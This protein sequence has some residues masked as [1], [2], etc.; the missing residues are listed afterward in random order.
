MK[1]KSIRTMISVVLLVSI[2]IGIIPGNVYASNG[3]EES[4]TYIP[5]MV[6]E[7]E[8]SFD[9]N[10]VEK[11]PDDPGEMIEASGDADIVAE[12][13]K[14]DEGAV[15]GKEEN[16]E[17]EE[18]VEAE[19]SERDSSGVL[20]ADEEAS[21][22]TA[23]GPEY[24]LENGVLTIT[25][26]GAI[27]EKLYQNNTEI[28]QIVMGEGISEI[29]DYAFYGCN[30]LESV[31]FSTSLTTIGNYAFSKCTGLE[32]VELPEGVST[33]GAR[34]FEN[35]TLLT[36]VTIPVSV[37]SG[38]VTYTYYS[39]SHKALG[40][41]NGCSNLTTVNFAEGTTHIHAGLFAGSGLKE[42][43]IPETVA[44][45]GDYAFASCTFLQ[46]INFPVSLE[47]ISGYVFAN[48]TALQNIE[49]PEGISEIGDYAFYKCTSLE[50]IEL[51][52]GLS[53]LGLRVF[54]NCKSLIEVTLSLSI[55]NGASSYTY[56]TSSHEAWGTF[57]GCS[58]L[59][60]VN[61][62]D[63]TTRIPGGLFAGSGIK[64]IT[65]PETVTEIGSYAF[66]SC[67]S[68]QGINFP[69]S[70]EKIRGHAFANCTALQNIEYPDGI[71]E[72]GDYT[73]YGC[74]S[75]ERIEFPEGLSTLGLRVF[76]NCKGLIE[77]TLSLSVLNGASSYTYNSSSHEA[78]GTFNGCSSLTTVNFPD[79]T[80]WIPGGF[81]AGSGIKEIVIPETVTAIGSYAFANSFLETI[82]I[83]DSVTAIGYCTFAVCSA[84]NY[85][86]MPKNW[87]KCTGF[88]SS[89]GV[90]A[91]GAI[92]YDCPL[93]ETVELPEGMTELPEYAFSNCKDIKYIVI[94]ESVQT[95]GDYSFYNCISL[96][97]IA[98]P[99]CIIT[100]PQYAFY[101]CSALLVINIP[102]TV[103][104]VEKDAFGKC[105]S[106]AQV[107]YAGSE[108]EWNKITVHTENNDVL[109]DVVINYDFQVTFFPDDFIG[110]W[111]GEY[112]GNHGSTVVRRHFV[113]IVDHYDMVSD[114]V[115]H[116][117]G[118]RTISQ[119]LENPSDFYAEGS[120]FVE[121]TVNLKTGAMSFQGTSW[122]EIPVGPEV[123]ELSSF[124]HVSYDG[125]LEIDKKSMHGINS[126]INTRT[127]YANLISS[128]SNANLTVTLS[129]ENMQYDLLQETVSFEKESAETATIVVTSDWGEAEAGKI[130]LFQKNVSV[131]SKTGVFLD[132]SPGKIFTPGESIYV[133]LIDA[134]NKVIETRKLKLK[135]E[136]ASSNDIQTTTWYDIWCVGDKYKSYTRGFTLQVGEERYDTG[137]SYRAEADIPKES[138]DQVSISKSGY[139][140]C[141]IPQ[142]LVYNCH[143]V[144]LY[145]DDTQ[146]AFAQ[147]IAIKRKGENTYTN[148]SASHFSIYESTFT[149]Y[150]M[151]VDLNWNGDSKD[152]VYLQQGDTIVELKEGKNEGLALGGF[153]TRSGGDIYLCMKSADGM[154][155][156]QKIYLD[157]YKTEVSDI[158]INGGEKS[159][160]VN[161]TSSEVDEIW[162]ELE[163]SLDMFN[164][165]FPAEL[166][167]TPTGSTEGTFYG[168]LGIDIK[169]K[170]KKKSIFKGVKDALAQTSGKNGYEY[171]S[172]DTIDNTIKALEN[173][174][175]KVGS[176]AKQ[177]VISVDTKVIGYVEGK[178]KIGSDG[179]LESLIFSDS[180]VATS[181]EG[182]FQTTRQHLVTP[183]PWYW[184]LELKAE[185]G[186]K[187]SFEHQ[188]DGTMAS[189]A[190]VES[191]LGIGLGAG[192]AAGLNGVISIGVSG[193]GMLHGDGQFLP[194]DFSKLS[195]YADYK[196]QLISLEVGSWVSGTLFSIDGE[197]YYLFRDNQW[198]PDSN[199]LNG[200]KVMNLSAYQLGDDSMEQLS[201]DYI[202]EGSEFTANEKLS[203]MNVLSNEARENYESVFKAN[204]YTFT[205]PQIVNLSDG[206]K[207]MV[208]VDD[209]GQDARPVDINRSAIYYS[210]FNGS[211]WSDPQIVW[212]DGTADSN[213][214]LRSIDGSVYLV[215]ANE[216]KAFTSDGSYEEYCAAM[217]VAYARFDVES[218]QFTEMSA[219]SNND[220]TDS[221]A[222]IT[223]IDGQPVVVWVQNSE[224]SIMQNS[225]NNTVYASRLENGNWVE[226]LLASDLQAIDGL[227]AA[228]ENGELIVYV[229][230]DTDGNAVTMED[231][232]IF[233][234][235]G[236]DVTQITNNEVID[237]KPVMIN[238]SL[239]W[240]CN[241][242]L[243]SDHVNT[244][245]LGESTDRYYYASNGDSAVV[246]YTKVNGDKSTTVYANYFDGN[247]WSEPVVAVES[248]YY[249]PKLSCILN[250]DGSVEIALNEV[251]FTDD[252]YGEAQI[253][254]C[255]IGKICDMSVED[256]FCNKQ[257]LKQGGYLEFT[258]N[259]RNNG[260]VDINSIDVSIRQGESE[261]YTQQENIDLLPGMEESIDIMCEI[262]EELSDELIIQITPSDLEDGDLSDNTATCKIGKK[263]VSVEEVTA[264]QSDDKMIVSAYIANRGLDVLEN[265]EISLHKDSADGT[266]LASQII[267]RIDVSKGENITFETEL[268]EDTIVYVVAK[269]CDS[270]NIISN[271]QGFTLTSE[272][273]SVTESQGEYIDMMS[274]TIDLSDDYYVYSG[275]AIIPTVTVKCGEDTLVENEDFEISYSNNINAGTATIT[276]K[277]IGDYRGTVTKEY[278]I[279][280]AEQIVYAESSA[281]VIKMGEQAA[282]TA[283]GV[284]TLSYESS[285]RSV[286][287]VDDAGVV[288]GLMPGTVV[289]TV[290]AA[291]NSNYQSAFATVNLIVVKGNGESDG[292]WKQTSKGWWYENPDGTYPNNCWKEIDGYWYYF[293]ASGYRVTGWQK[294][295][296]TWYYFDPTTGIMYE[297]QWMELAGKSYYLKK[298]GVMATGWLELE[299]GWYYLNSSGIRVTGWMQSGGNW[300]YLDPVT[301][302]MF[303]NQWLENTY[304]LKSGGAMVTGWQKIDGKWY[305]FQSS[306]AKAT[307]WLKSGSSWYYF[308][309]TTGIM[310][311]SEWLDN[312]YYL[313]SS[314]AMAT[315]WLLIGEDY[316]YFDASGKKVTGKW[317]GNYYLKADGVMARSEWVD[318]DRYY[319]DENGK[320]VPGEKR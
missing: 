210:I 51:P 245:T 21:D 158:K 132:I 116:I 217:D 140:T 284:G 66:A 93:L 236:Q 126:N 234:I 37:E 218:G 197:K 118:T 195:V 29:G 186:L 267:K 190:P 20:F 10:Y 101:N 62:P 276:I 173:A 200:A 83:P 96:T 114:S 229:S 125:F 208:W 270:E 61:F 11:E 19:V 294:I 27:T 131:E 91:Q 84:L 260:N 309:P 50:R 139:I 53:T 117:S 28:T 298:G 74:T 313:K 248:D 77:V 65:I 285:D 107:N 106:L 112:D 247:V 31:S 54:E 5:E 12:F 266:A 123:D 156:K 216:N 108:E 263:D 282:I 75:L 18:A 69:A 175:N 166:T 129:Q 176:Y 88:N 43:T 120:D 109:S 78:W 8:S 299:E 286:A 137:D 119:S 162:G 160:G 318:N 283:S 215:W 105:S 289:I 2:I 39:T 72:L 249:V 136:P 45:I 307:G 7:S 164:D 135:I 228:G 221:L 300:Y 59:T 225:G 179:K 296:N 60:T 100:I 269:E 230:Q 122:I 146:N 49:Y 243:V 287:M 141:D 174:G 168:T 204:T 124:M 314:G 90:S 130:R 254:T 56:N 85:A 187:M 150:D 268:P 153:F 41:F 302:V 149:T 15:E 48:C 73:F 138:S 34:A 95:L 292:E 57:N 144:I 170:E 194:M 67:K 261:L 38:S 219:V 64:E 161:Q 235:S 201:R 211:S 148:L 145:P 297:E 280:K 246:L 241:G 244:I 320:W 181:L 203:A 68:L 33:I 290:T 240:Y 273:E 291:G 305:Y 214:V 308:E 63:N 295:K 281:S 256:V 76:E 185:L 80:T 237:S 14:P 315:G 227:C 220:N 134:E 239:Y 87:S 251:E 44:T 128:D 9:A 311:E 98:L 198:F 288:T 213:P 36:E 171:I 275:K 301:G 102:E 182:S 99:A 30:N 233:K 70:L 188:Y 310:Y 55:L 231:K 127:Y 97:S 191:S 278:T 293:N 94:P 86:H 16:D 40:I 177:F 193:E 271:N 178:Y 151:Y 223:V 111:E 183:V 304:Y 206:S 155:W 226:S 222:D 25:G 265:I 192:V 113:F 250:D 202:T 52:E 58:S 23:S 207:L 252:G 71:K 258:A 115:I 46:R 110:V 1:R 142:E 274:C 255:T 121:G 163:F 17:K 35:C 264:Q 303:E 147:F 157:V 172:D 238:G 165:S 199:L 159:T 92:F 167:L 154:I 232:E 196:I 279:Q 253:R 312:T 277:G 6:L 103:T 319:V 22:G 205:E 257:A 242:N 152:S 259:V 82:E 4:E 3:D 89:T 169:N 13:E 104:Y 317:V 47:K 184:Q 79:H 81:F 26:N 133:S 209:A 262:P 224:N 189:I 42:I 32:K 24:V 272:S 212:D 306:G 143:E 316:Y 180:G